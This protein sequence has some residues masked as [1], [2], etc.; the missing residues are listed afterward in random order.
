[1]NIE[2]EFSKFIEFPEGSDGMYVTT[3]SAKLF[4]EH[5]IEQLKQ[6]RDELRETISELR[7]A[8][9]FLADLRA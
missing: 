6:E 7:Q 3:V 4:A 9:Q 2:E 5:C 8:N 1:M